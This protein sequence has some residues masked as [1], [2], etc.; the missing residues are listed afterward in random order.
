MKYDGTNLNE[1]LEEHRKWTSGEG[2]SE[3]DLTGADFDRCRL[4]G[5][6][7][8]RASAGRATFAKVSAQ[9][10]MAQSLAAPRSTWF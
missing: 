2:G 7:L 9:R 3:A 4:D 8:C 5:A 6:S 1:V 10:L